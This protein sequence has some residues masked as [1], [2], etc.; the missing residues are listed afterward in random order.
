[1]RATYANCFLPEGSAEA[2]SELLLTEEPGVA[3][4]A[5]PGTRAILT[6]RL[7]DPDRA[8]A[9]N[10]ALWDLAFRW[11][12]I[13]GDDVTLVD[14]ISAAD[15]GGGEAVL[16]TLIPAGR[17]VLGMLAAIESGLEVNALATRVAAQGPRLYTHTETIAA[18]AAA[19]AARARF[20]AAL[21]ISA[22]TVVDERNGALFT[23][24]TAT[25]DVDSLS[26]ALARGQ[27]R[28]SAM[29]GAANL[30]ARLRGRRGRHR[31]LL[32]Y[33]YNPTRVFAETYETMAD[34]RWRL[35][36]H[37]CT[38]DAV[39]GIVAAGDRISAAPRYPT[40]LDDA[41]IRHALTAACDERAEALEAA[42]TL[43]GV[44]LWPVVRTALIETAERHAAFART[45]APTLRRSLERLDVDA[46]LVPFES[47]PEARALLRVAQT[48]GIPTHILSDGFKADDF[49]VD[50]TLCDVALSWSTSMAEHYYSRRTHGRVEVTGNPKSDRQLATGATRSRGGDR[51]RILIGSFTFS[52]ADINCRRSDPER[53]LEDILDGIARC[54]RSAEAEVVIKLH[55]ADREGHYREILDRH[56]RLA[57][58]VVGQGD[59]IAMFPAHDVYITT[60]STSLIEA[61]PLGLPVIYHRANPQ[62]LHP[63]FS[64]DAFL[65]SRTA[66]DAAGIARLLDDPATFRLPEPGATRAWAERYLG[67]T[68]GRSTQRVVEAVD[69]TVNRL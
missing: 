17:G 36:R 45:A 2:A 19:A 57:P 8:Q 50:G 43:E 7:I 25:R 37:R 1:M 49:T 22:E 65:E 4:A 10:I 41:E 16:R 14:G 40:V 47:P 54:A 27:A 39:A 35:A 69:R 67:P 58:A 42:F 23:K 11:A 55:P 20:G 68:D 13:G 29:T 24:Y 9:A 48:M 61:V 46:V 15:L 5:G 31:T 26:P 18:A 66:D 33:D 53:F 34:R 38:V 60:Y 64:D 56:R 63:P 6:D 59:V 44:S 28:R 52:P 3:A 32:V 51:L 21:P 12:R 62:R 30:L